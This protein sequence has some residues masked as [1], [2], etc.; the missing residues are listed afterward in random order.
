MPYQI[1]NRMVIDSEWGEIEYRMPSSNRMKRERQ[2]FEEAER[3]DS[4][5]VQSW[6]QGCMD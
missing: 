1:E 6:R 2:A 4:D 5:C 3:E